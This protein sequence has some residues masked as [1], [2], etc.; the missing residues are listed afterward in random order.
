RQAPANRIRVLLRSL[1]STK[2]T[3][4]A[5]ASRVPGR[6][7]PAVRRRFAAR[8]AGAFRIAGA[9]AP[10]RRAAALPCGHGRAELSRLRGRGDERADG[11]GGAGPGRAPRA[12][13]G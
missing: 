13:P 2:G 3:L 9:P 7:A 10:E 11:R 8:R 1:T 12:R 6:G 4:A 5:L